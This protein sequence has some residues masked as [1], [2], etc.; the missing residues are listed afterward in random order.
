MTS[1]SV[2]R[3]AGLTCVVLAAAVAA[4]TITTSGRDEVTGG[5]A[6]PT[7]TTTGAELVAFDSCESVLNGFRAAATPHVGPYGFTGAANRGGTEKGGIADG[8]AAA[9][10]VAAEAGAAPP[11]QGT[12]QAETP[13][14]S[15]TNTHESGVDEPDLVK[16]DGR[17][18]VT[19]TGST[20]RVVDVATR[21]VTG[22][23]PLDGGYASEMLL[24]GDR[25][26]V[27][28]TSAMHSTGPARGPARDLEMGSHLV[29]VDLA[30]RPT[31]T[32]TLTVDGAYVGARQVDGVARLVVRSTPR[33]GF[34]YPTLDRPSAAAAKENRAILESAPVEDWLPRYQLTAGGAR[35][36]GRLVD[37]DR[38]RHPAAY[39]GTAML[40]MLTLDL[41]RDL[42][43]GDPITIT[44][45]GD[46]VYGTGRSLYVADDRR[47]H[48]AP[49]RALTPLPRPEVAT[50]TEIHRFEISGTAPPRYAGSGRVE[51]TLL[52]QYSLSEHAG[53]LR[54][55]T[56]I[57]ST[58]GRAP[59]SESVVS[60]L[61]Q[62]GDRLVTVGSVGGLGRG[63]RIHA[64]RFIGPLGYVVTFRQTDPLYTVD[65][66]DPARPKAV[67]ELK[68]TG[69]SAYLHP[70]GEN[71]LIGVGQEATEQGV[72]LGT[73]VSL[74][75]VG[76][77]AAPRRI[78]QYQ[79]PGG[80]SEVEFDPHAFLYWPAKNLLVVPLTS[81]SGGTERFAPAP[82]S[83]GALVLR[84]E[85][86]RISEVGR[87]QHPVASGEGTV[88]RAIVIGDQL[89]TVSEAGLLVTG[90][91]LAAPG[92]WVPFR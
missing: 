42:G 89:W 44:A 68:I 47:A 64:V 80:S 75:D 58:S 43:T 18:I 48:A 92:S 29:L 2:L 34:V 73:Q 30:G 14:H 31:V 13:E 1:A 15:T 87:I 84:L 46:T 9:P 62:Q 67:G 85:P 11:A 5:D 23:L 24:A 61:A 10:D 66:S 90:L 37:C 32:S 28:V 39:S 45:D 82:P 63:E 88:R 40:T 60:V 33:L 16:T 20:L 76:A 36:E 4:V 71:R 83:G 57:G 86:G 19:V 91:D 41:A 50:N 54:V 26:L 17:R 81:A 79:V 7:V 51:G 6:P 53:H 69:Y 74:F 3:K 35:S 52:N 70:A 27:I 12:D 25:A 49:A 72:R 78:A 77:P 65:L 38:V 55:A 21:Q 56:T 59:S 8:R 22:S